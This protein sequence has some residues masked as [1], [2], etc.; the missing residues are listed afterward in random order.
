MSHRQ[1]RGKG[2]RLRGKVSDE[3]G[4]RIE[5]GRKRSS[6]KVEGQKHTLTQGREETKGKGE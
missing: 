4:R 1:R 2:R 6:M 3:M 5:A